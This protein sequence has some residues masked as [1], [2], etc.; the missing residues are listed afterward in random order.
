MQL[1]PSGVAN[2]VICVSVGA[3]LINVS[4]PFTPSHLTFY[5][6]NRTRIFFF[7]FSVLTFPGRLDA[8]CVRPHIKTLS[9]FVLKYTRQPL[10]DSKGRD[11]ND[12]FMTL[13]LSGCFCGERDGTYDSSPPKVPE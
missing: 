3:H 6:K 9:L 13:P 5:F 10:N 7:F 8:A 2:F 4:V 1:S 11:I 12:L